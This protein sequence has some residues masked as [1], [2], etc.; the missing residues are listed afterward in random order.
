MRVQVDVAALQP[1]L[2]GDVRLVLIKLGPGQ[3]EP[4]MTATVRLPAS[5]DAADA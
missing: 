3:T 2:A 4:L 5:E 1:G